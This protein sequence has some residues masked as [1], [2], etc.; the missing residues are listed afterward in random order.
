V[1]NPAPSAASTCTPL[2]YRDRLSTIWDTIPSVNQSNSILNNKINGISDTDSSPWSPRST[3]T[4][5]FGSLTDPSS[6]WGSADAFKQD[7]I[8]SRTASQTNRQDE[9]GCR[10]TA[11]RSPFD[12]PDVKL[13]AEA[14]LSPANKYA[15]NPTSINTTGTSFF[16]NGSVPSK[17]TNPPQRLHRTENHIDH[18]QAGN[19]AYLGA[20]GT[21]NNFSLFNQLGGGVGVPSFA[22]TPIAAPIPLL[23]QYHSGSS[24]ASTGMNLSSLNQLP[25]RQSYNLPPRLLNLAKHQASS[26]ASR[27]PSSPDIDFFKEMGPLPLPGNNT[28]KGTAVGAKYDSNTAT[29]ASHLSTMQGLMNNEGC[30][31][32]EENFNLDTREFPTLDA[33]GND[34]WIEVKSSKKPKSPT[35]KLAKGDDQQKNKKGKKRSKGSGATIIVSG[36]ISP[37][38]GYNSSNS[39]SQDDISVEEK[40]ESLKEMG[41][42]KKHAIKAL[43]ACD[44]DLARAV[45]W[46]ILNAP[47][48]K[49]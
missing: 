16:S 37:T 2:G 24:G 45:D 8:N 27:E 32:I 7:N 39:Q 28:K 6:I 29:S 30:E 12:L 4:R 17:S 11:F 20:I 48:K 23:P 49:D 9:N 25:R 3:E 34:D 31:G 26:M 1:T 46:L 33:S 15:T 47:F 36:I 40:I 44:K 5:S 35:T 14:A 19:R 13:L 18:S 41:F 22:S 38:H 43:Q 10:A 42:E 21:Q